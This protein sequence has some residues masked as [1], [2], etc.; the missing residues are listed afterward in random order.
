VAAL[1]S[2]VASRGLSTAVE[3]LGGYR[4]VPASFLDFLAYRDTLRT[5]SHNALMLAESLPSLFR[6]SVPDEFTALSIAVWLGCWIGPVFI[7]VAFFQRLSKATKRTKWTIPNSGDFIEDVLWAATALCFLAY[8]LSSIPKDRT[9]T[10]YLIPVVFCAS[11]ASSRALVN[12]KVKLRAVIVCLS[13]LAMA[14]AFTVLAD[15]RKP[16]ATDHAVHLADW[17]A[18]HSLRF[19]YAP[20]WDASIVTASSEGRVAVRPIFVRAISPERHKIMPLPWMTDARWFAEEPA[21]FIVLEPGPQSS[22]Q[23][24]LTERNCRVSF[25]S[26]TARYEVGPYLVLVWDQD[27][28]TRLDK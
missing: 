6:C 27:L 19:G 14:Y 2:V 17:L 24:G 26:M 25:G 23:F 20:F 16:P 21:T 3:R 11:V 5:V 13:L 8:L 18:S 22:Y 7:C 4:V 12:R 9:S 1:G 10:R 15:L 28:R